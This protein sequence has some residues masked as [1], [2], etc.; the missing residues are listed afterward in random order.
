MIDDQDNYEAYYA[1]KLWT[2]LPAIYRALDTDQFNSN[3]PLRELVNRIGAKA[4]V[5][6]RSIDRL[7]EDQSIETCDDWV[8]AY[9]GDLVATNLVNNLDTRSQRVDVARTIYY[10]RRKGTLGVLEEIAANITGW[11]AKVVEF[12]RRLGRTRHN[13]DPALGL[14]LAPGD[15]VFQLQVAEGLIGSLTGTGIGGLADLRNVNGASKVGTAFDEFFHTADFRRGQARVGWYSIPRLGV[16][17]W[18]L[19]SF[20][21]GPTTPV[22]VH[23][24]PG[25]YTFDP[26]GRDIPLFAASR[27]S[28]SYGDNWASP[29]EGQ[30]PTPISQA[31]FDAQDPANPL[32]PV[33]MGVY[34]SPAPDATAAP[35]SRHL[36]VRPPHGRFYASHHAPV[37]HRVWTTY[38]YG[39]SS[40]I[41]AG[42]YDRRVGQ[43]TLPAP[44]PET[45][46]SGGHTALGGSNAIPPTGTVTITDSLTYTE[47]HHVPVLGQLTVRAG[48]KQRPII[49]PTP[50]GG[51]WAQWK[52][53][54]PKATDAEASCLVLDGLLLTG[55]DIILDGNFDCVTLSCC[56]LDPGSVPVKPG[57]KVFAVAADGR[58]LVPCRLWIDGTVNTLTIDR[59]ITGPIRTRGSGTVQT[60]TVTDSILQAI[61]TAGSWPIE[62]CHIKDLIGFIERLL[63]VGRAVLEHLR[64]AGC[65][66]SSASWETCPSPQPPPRSGEG[67]QSRSPPCQSP[68][69]GRLAPPLRFGEGVG[70]RGSFSTA[71]GVAEAPA[72]R[73]AEPGECPAGGT[74]HLR[75]AGVPGRAAVGD[76]AALAGA[77]R[78]PD[79]PGAEPEPPPVGG[80]A[81]P[82]AG[83]YGPGVQRWRRD[84]VALHRPRS[85]R[86][87]STPGQRVHPRGTGASGRLAARL[88]PLHGLGRRQRSASA[89][90]KCPHSARRGA[91]HI[92]RFRAAGLLPAAGDGRRSDPAAARTTSALSA[93]DLEGGARWLRDGR[94]FPRPEPH[95]GARV[96]DQVPG[97]HAGRVGPGPR[98]RDLRFARALPVVPPSSQPLSPIS[99]ERAASAG[100]PGSQRT[101]PCRAT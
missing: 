40:E 71:G 77:A 92:H 7:W 26:T 95:Q 55:T 94:F 42:P 76:D 53:T 13:L 52:F 60:L 69:F 12:F 3:G 14:S 23:G 87:P 89:V 97:I 67:E 50:S 56:T 59:C 54:G 39:F 41:G 9:I 4:A 64:A 15:A 22:P 88:R 27:T 44:T 90:R 96:A 73:A 101:D 91:I 32:Y 5:L 35:L 51:P 66:G 25:W 75:S 58:D 48:V 82:G 33:V 29:A 83:R 34:P 10:R 61:P 57:S 30:L 70:G 17:L 18:R 65:R 8:I 19:I 84:P 80:R 16:F 38:H 68:H 43:A 20:D 36:Q 28:A 11:D 6:R 86:G 74:I 1:N 45:L 72:R 62:H 2:L 21:V 93:D 63:A 78:L 47:V 31:L 98:L 85:H 99:G 49:R 24:C 81:A 37:S 100:R 46:F 79:E